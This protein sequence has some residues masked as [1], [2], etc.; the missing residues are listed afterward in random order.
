M[1]NKRPQH[2]KNFQCD[3]CPTR[4]SWV[5]IIKVNQISRQMCAECIAELAKQC[6]KEKDD[7]IKTGLHKQTPDNASSD[8]GISDQPLQE[9]TPPNAN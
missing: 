9:E 2:Q 6:R 3:F 5:R 7:T 1:P 4:N 8:R